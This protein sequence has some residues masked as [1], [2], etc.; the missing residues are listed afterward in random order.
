[1]SPGGSGV[2]GAQSTAVLTINDDDATPSLSIND[3][4]LAEGNS[5]T[6]TF[7]FTVTLSAASG[8]PVT[9]SYVT[10]DGTADGA[11]YTAVPSTLLTFNPGDLNKTVDVLVTGDIF[12]EANETFFVNLSSPTNATIADN[13]G[14]GTIQNDDASG[15]VLVLSAATYSVAE[16][17]GAATITVNRTGSLTQAVSIDYATA[18]ITANENKDYTTA[19]GTIKFA[20]GEASRTFTVLINQDAFA[21]PVET[22]GLTLSNA[23]GGA[24]L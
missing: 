17:A 14:L 5:G 8:L 4:S 21:E 1:S 12:S 18:D 7:T 16:N 24:V 20:A 6:T 22:V 3:V 2:L 9:V 13:Q 19:V 23:S 11:D 10:A 15:G